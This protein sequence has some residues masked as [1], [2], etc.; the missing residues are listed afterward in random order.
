ASDGLGILLT[1]AGVQV[2]EYR[3]RVLRP[4][5]LEVPP[6]EAHV[7][8]QI[9]LRRRLLH[10]RLEQ[11]DNLGRP[12][13]LLEHL[14]SPLAPSPSPRLLLEH[15]IPQLQRLRPSIH[16]SVELCESRQRLRVVRFLLAYP[17]LQPL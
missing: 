17:R 3:L 9:D 14:P 16:L 4:P 5:G 12:A 2:L 1:T 7:R 11:R 6:R 15:L 13:H 8:I 10:L